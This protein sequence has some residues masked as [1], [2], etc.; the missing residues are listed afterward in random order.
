[1]VLYTSDDKFKVEQNCPVQIREK[2][3]LFKKDFG[4]KLR[5]FSL[6]KFKKTIIKSIA[7]DIEQNY[8]DAFQM[9]EFFIRS[10]SDGNT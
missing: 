7:N 9:E 4:K 1:M 8:P 2:F 5:Y 6:L 3:T 10:N